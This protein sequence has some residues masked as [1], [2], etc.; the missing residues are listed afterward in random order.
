[1]QNLSTEMSITINATVANI[2]NVLINP[3]KIAQYLFGS[4]VETDW[5]PGTP[6][7]FSRIIDGKSYVDK[8]HILE[9]I[10]EQLL[11]FTYWSSQEGYSDIPENYSVITFLIK[12]DDKLAIWLTYR[13]EKIPT[14]FEQKNQEQF[15]PF[16]LENIKTL[17]ELN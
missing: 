11:K 5:L 17:A 6:I 3:E 1:M 15:L 9:I 4:Q 14:A 16:M 7:T 13:R 12:K 2:W 10:A 8:G